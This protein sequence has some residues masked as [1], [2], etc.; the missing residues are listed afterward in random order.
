MRML[1]RALV[2]LDRSD[3]GLRELRCGGRPQDTLVNPVGRWQ[4]RARAAA[5]LAEMRD[6]EGAARGTQ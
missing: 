3:D 5:A 1:G 4:A 2:R 6:E